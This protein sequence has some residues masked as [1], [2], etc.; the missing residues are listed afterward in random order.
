MSP[1]KSEVIMNEI[2]KSQTPLDIKN[3]Q[4]QQLRASEAFATKT[5]ERVDGVRKFTVK[6][7]TNPY[8]RVRKQ[9]NEA[10]GTRC[11]KKLCKHRQ[12]KQIR[13]T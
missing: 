9:K 5:C 13:E 8:K 12:S 7:I 1:E 2:Q 11:V 6:F 3:P 4:K 10:C